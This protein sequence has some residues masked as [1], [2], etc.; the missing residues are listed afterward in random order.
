MVFFK[1]QFEFG[2]CYVYNQKKY[3]HEFQTCKKT[4]LNTNI[5]NMKTLLKFNPKHDWKN[6]VEIIL[7]ELLN[8][9][10]PMHSELQG[11][12]LTREGIS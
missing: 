7:G 6:K 8:D 5:K 2:C 4:N 10:K 11:L 3:K 12:Q 9:I 1:N